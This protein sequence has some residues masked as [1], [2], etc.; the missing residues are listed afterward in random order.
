MARPIKLMD[1]PAIHAQLQRGWLAIAPAPQ[2]FKLGWAEGLPARAVMSGAPDQKFSLKIKLDEPYL[3]KKRGNS[4]EIEVMLPLRSLDFYAALRSIYILFGTQ[5]LNDFRERNGLIRSSDQDTGDQS[6]A[7]N[8]MLRS[9]TIIEEYAENAV[10]FIE[11]SAQKVALYRLAMAREEIKTEARKYFPKMREASNLETFLSASALTHLGLTLDESV[12][13]SSRPVKQVIANLIEIKELSARH[14]S[15]RDLFQREF[16]A[17]VKEHPLIK[18]D[19]SGLP[20]IRNLAE[21]FTTNDPDIIQLWKKYGTAEALLIKT[22]STAALE[23]PILWRIHK[24]A[25]PRQISLLGKQMLNTLKDTWDANMNLTE[26]IQEDAKQVWKYHSV[27]METLRNLEVPENSIA[28]VA[29]QECLS[30]GQDPGLISTLS[31]ISGFALLGVAA[32]PAVGLS[33]A[34]SPLIIAMASADAVLSLL[35]AG[36]TYLEYRQASAAYNACLDPALALGAEPSM[37][38]TALS[39]TFDVLGAIP[40]TPGR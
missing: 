18:T 13:E 17:R 35:S 31:M 39:I 24:S 34:A 19:F 26:E 22:V 3:K 5:G 29:A 21:R 27:V 4:N 25:D 11:P 28:W 40:G 20:S 15:T 36:N 2:E 6:I 7:Y 38:S 32:A 33:I 23:H 30:Q 37:L 9:R 8:L 16:Q 12:H 1:T 10:A 14:A